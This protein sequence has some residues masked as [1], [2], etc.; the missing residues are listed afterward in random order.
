M[1]TCINYVEYFEDDDF[2]ED[3]ISDYENEIFE[4]ELLAVFGDDVI[5]W[6]NRRMQ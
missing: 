1:P 2:I 6:I 5:E 4:Q 3:N